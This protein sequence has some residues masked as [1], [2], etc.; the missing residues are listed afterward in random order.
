M[1]DELVTQENIEN[2]ISEE[3]EKEVSEV[4]RISSEHEKEATE[5]GIPLKMTGARY[6]IYQT[7]TSD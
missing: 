6:K 5:R 1:K 7:I 2:T 4:S 3:I